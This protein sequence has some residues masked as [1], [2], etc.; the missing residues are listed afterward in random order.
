MFCLSWALDFKGSK[1][2]IYIV[3]SKTSILFD[4]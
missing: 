2:M 4:F 3:K 1:L